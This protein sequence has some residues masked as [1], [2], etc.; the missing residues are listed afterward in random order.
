MQVDVC[1]L[2]TGVAKPQGYSRRVHPTL[3]QRHRTGMPPISR[4]TV[5]VIHVGLGIAGVFNGIVFRH[6]IS[7][8]FVVE[9]GAAT[10]RMPSRIGR[11]SGCT[12]RGLHYSRRSSR[13][14]GEP[15]DR[16]LRAFA[17]GTAG[18][19]DLA[20]PR[21]VSA[22][23]DPDRHELVF[24]ADELAEVPPHVIHRLESAGG[25]RVRSAVPTHFAT[26]LARHRVTAVLTGEGPDELT[27]SLGPMHDINLQRVQA[28]S[29]S[30][31]EG[32]G[33]QPRCAPPPPA[34]DGLGWRP[35]RRILPLPPRLASAPRRAECR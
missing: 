29:A 34:R 20:T 26:I 2:D 10:G 7:L 22:H 9:G 28:S 5:D 3:Q 23:V 19:P 6:R 1:G 14:R 21:A 32:A 13:T 25:D 8:G 35:S 24:T 16:P 4:K 33:M 31:A 27:R 12:A 17:V 30:G 15:I 18:S 11:W